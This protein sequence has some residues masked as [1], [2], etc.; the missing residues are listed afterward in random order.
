VR[1]HRYALV[2]ALGAAFLVPAVLLRAA[3]DH[4]HPTAATPQE[5]TARRAEI[6]QAM[7][8]VMGELPDRASL[9]PV[10]VKLGEE[11]KGDGFTRISLTYN[12]DGYDRVPAHLYLPE[13]REPRKKYPA[14]VA[15]HQT[16]NLGKQDLG[17]GAKNPNNSYVPELVRRGYV[18]I[19]PDYPSFGE[20]ASY[21]FAKDPYESGT[22][23]GIV[24]HI[25]AIDVLSS[26][27]D[28]DPDR[29]GTIGHSLGGHNAIFLGVFDERVKV[30]VSSCGWTPFHDYYGGKLKG[31]TQDRYMPRIRDVYESNPDKVP[32]DFPELIAALAPRAIFSVS[33][34]KDANFDVAGVKRG[35]A[36]ATPIYELLGAKDKLQVRYPED[37]HNFS[38][39]MRAE[40]FAFIDRVLQ[41]ENAAVPAAA[42]HVPVEE[43][44]FSA[45]LPR[46][47]P[48]EPADAL[49]TFQTLPGFH[50]ELAASEPNVASPVAIDF[51]EDGRMFVCEMRD[52]SEQ[53]KERL[54]TI[55]ML[56]DADNDGTYEKA[57]V[58]A[59]DLSWPTALIC[60]DGGLFVGAAPDIYWL[61]DTDGDGK[62]DQRKTVFTG[63]SRSN[64]QGLLNCFRWGLD[65]RIHGATG[66]SGGKVRR[67][68]DPE[69]KAVDLSGR[70]FSFDPRTLELRAESGGAQHG[71][72]FD[73]FGRKFV[74]SNSDHIQMVMIDDRYLARNPF[75]NVASARES[76]AADGPQA[77]VFRISPVEPWRIVRTRLRASGAVKGIVEFGGQP[78]GYFTGAT[79]V[80]IYRGDAFGPEYRGQAFCGDVGS[81][82]VHR[83][84][85][86]PNG[87]GF[88]ADRADAGKEFVAS[89]DTWFRPAQFANAPDGTLYVID[90]Y[91]EVI[92]HPASLP[93]MIK[94]HLDL[95]SGRDRGRIWRVV[96]DGYKR[97]PAP[98]L[99]K[100]STEELVKLLEHQNGWHRDA[101]SRLLYQRQEASSVPLLAR[102]AEESNVPEAQVHA[103]YGLAAGNELRASLLGVCLRSGVNPRVQ[104]HAIRLTEMLPQGEPG[105]SGMTRSKELSQ[106]DD[107]RVRYQFALTL[108]LTD[109]GRRRGELAV[110]ELLK[111]VGTDRWLL[112]AVIAVVGDDADQALLELFQDKDFLHAP[113]TRAVV[114]E[115]ARQLGRHNDSEVVQAVLTFAP[116]GFIAI[117]DLLIGVSD[118]LAS[119]GTSLTEVMKEWP[120]KERLDELLAPANR[121]AVDEKIDFVRRAAAIRVLGVGGFDR[122]KDALAKALGGDAP[123]D[124]QVAALAVLDRFNDAGVGEILTKAWP[125]MTPATRNA[126]ANVLFARPERAAAFLDA[127]D[128]GKIKA[129]DVDHARLK[130]LAAGD[131]ARLRER[132]KKLLTAAPSAARQQVFESFQSSLSLKGDAARGKLTFE[133]TC[134]SCH[135]LGDVGSEI[136]PNLA[137]MQARGAEAV[138]L[139]VID[140]NREV[141]PQYVDYVVQTK[142]GRTTTGLLASET[143]GGI[144]LKRA[145][146]ETETIAR[147]DIKRMRSSGL[148]IMP[149][150]L[151][152][153]LDQQAMA[154]LVAYVLSAN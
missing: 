53:D 120:D 138:L 142:S 127:V 97:P 2:A 41:N 29:I 108:G 80:T 149:E 26:R 38:P 24:N 125:G 121:A 30:V 20:Y 4:R 140:P 23:K 146:G 72:C 153:G 99:S 42:K 43:Q 92:E 56:E 74:A 59:D 62:A 103:L 48:T 8:Q 60:Y 95:T 17:G 141:N 46:I 1:L 88:I 145:G 86:K 128:A 61:K 101:A 133:K 65:N 70:D 81:N 126:A 137:A 87:V 117:D 55:R 69:S 28:V 107:P 40:A 124:V 21:D 102:M 136:G 151:E 147:T 57:T 77:R 67:P 118:G 7:Q 78:A 27:D 109:A 90:V 18:V 22:M 115:L 116:N 79:G 15:L 68:E 89:T 39:A 83:K 31:W 64:V 82:I 139:N 35:I 63:F 66:T 105:L 104:E 135:R 91:R 94:K 37:E 114:R 13:R 49:K 123:G 85:L 71:M 119:S 25:R 122:S 134:A 47:A 10:D 34:T 152:Q 73:D 36:A 44:D 150:G 75:L 100:A 32:F 9:P 110:R 132:A 144:T 131:N 154:D 11:T 52:Y 5:W 130:T 143:A 148:S 51:D 106:N 45:E 84:I 3:G 16:S 112:A 19:C 98:K 50:M 6:L 14:I 12:A 93:P 54:G 96:P 33:P 113:G 76:I 111:R 58:F 129:S